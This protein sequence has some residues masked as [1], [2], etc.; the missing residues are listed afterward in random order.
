MKI[1]VMNSPKPLRRLLAKI[2]GV[3]INKKQHN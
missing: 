2:F 3:E 1:I